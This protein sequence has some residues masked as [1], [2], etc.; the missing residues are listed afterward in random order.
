MQGIKNVIFDLGGVILNINMKLM[1]NALKELGIDNVSEYIKTTGLASFF[2][3]YEIGK[4]SD[5]DFITSI[6]SLS[7]TGVKKQ[8][9]IDAWNILL[10]DY[11]EERLE[12]L[13]SLKGKYRLFL[14]SNTNSLHHNEFQK[15]LFDQTGQYMEDF[16]EKA[17]YSHTIG[18][19]KPD[20]AAFE[21][22]IEENGLAPTETLFLDDSETNIIGAQKAGLQTIHIKPG[23]TILDIK[24]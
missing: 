16:F 22:V 19:S 7:A 18:L 24:W 8:A 2:K 5:E 6:Q 3:E 13:R 12:L 21:Y 9:I 15:R 23:V 14:L 11:P 20:T 17:Y 4:I 10:L 1:E